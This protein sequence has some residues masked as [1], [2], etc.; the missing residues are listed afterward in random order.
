MF[1]P[2]GRKVL[3]SVGQIWQRFVHNGLDILD[4]DFAEHFSFV[5]LYYEEFLIF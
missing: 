4:I 3:Q 1:L 2:R 5:Y